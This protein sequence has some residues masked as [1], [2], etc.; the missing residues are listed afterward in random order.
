[1]GLTLAFTIQSYK[2]QNGLPKCVRNQATSICIFRTRDLSEVKAIQES[3]GGEVDE[4]TFYALYREA[5][6]GN[7][8]D[9]LFIDI[10]KLKPNQA[11]MFRRN[12]DEYLIVSKEDV[13]KK[14]V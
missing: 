14:E 10:G 9:F 3:F 2:A 7:L 13:A 11:S 5:T 6:E 8:H 1:M 12:F 4:D